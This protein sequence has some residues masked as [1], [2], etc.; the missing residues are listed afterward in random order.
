METYGIDNV[1]F[2]KRDVERVKRIATFEASNDQGAWEK[3]RSILFRKVV[4]CF[5]CGPVSE[6]KERPGIQSG[7]IS[8]S[9]KDY[10]IEPFLVR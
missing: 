10:S 2:D 5:F 7:L 9:R 6:F 1:Y 8:L 4:Q 3:M